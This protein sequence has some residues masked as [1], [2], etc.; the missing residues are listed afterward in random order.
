MLCT[1]NLLHHGLQGLQR[2]S[3]SEHVTLLS[4][5]PEDCLVGCFS[6]SCYYLPV[7]AVT[8]AVAAKPGPLFSSA[9]MGGEQVSD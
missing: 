6:F 4:L 1:L 7:V 5:S 9:R 2:E 8:L 3:S